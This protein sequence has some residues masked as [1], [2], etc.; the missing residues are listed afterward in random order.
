[1]AAN[2]HVRVLPLRWTAQENTFVIQ[3]TWT[4]EINS[5]RERV[6]LQL[7]SSARSYLAWLNGANPRASVSWKIEPTVVPPPVP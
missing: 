7:N 4:V 2:F 6:W 1:M 5:E 3:D